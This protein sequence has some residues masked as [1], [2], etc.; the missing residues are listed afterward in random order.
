MLKSIED[1]SENLKRRSDKVV[2]S[3]KLMM[4]I[5]ETQFLKRIG[6]EEI[7][8]TPN[9]FIYSFKANA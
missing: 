8:N 6:K 5:M 2:F 1:I 9:L 3:E 4:C 7:Y